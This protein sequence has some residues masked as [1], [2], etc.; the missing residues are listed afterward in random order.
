MLDRTGLT[1]LFDI[2]IKYQPPDPLGRFLDE[3]GLALPDLRSALEDQLGLEV[4]SARA[5]V[6][7]V[8]IDT[9]ERPTPN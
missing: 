6:E 1:G 2:D 7:V 9:I 5:P 4:E 8:V 3:R